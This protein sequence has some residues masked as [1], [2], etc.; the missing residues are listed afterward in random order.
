MVQGKFELLSHN[1]PDKLHWHGRHDALRLTYVNVRH[2]IF[3]HQNHLTIFLGSMGAL[4][5]LR[6]V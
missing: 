4:D 2:S 6:E 5:T 1:G 3:T